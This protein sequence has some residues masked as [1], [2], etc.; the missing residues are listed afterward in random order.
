M[1]SRSASGA[2]ERRAASVPGGWFRGRFRRAI[3]PRP[4]LIIVGYNLL[5]QS[6]HWFNEL[7]SFKS[8][9][10]GLGL[11]VQI[12]VPRATE[13]PLAAALSADPVLESLPPLEVNAENFVT[14][15]VAFG[16]AAEI[17]QLLWA[18]L[19]AENPRQADMIYFPRGHPVL[20]RA[21]GLWLAKQ[22]PARRPNVFFRI[23][24]DEL[25]DLETGRFK[26]RASFYRLACADLRMQPGQER[27]FFLVNSAAKARSVSRVCCRQAF[28]MQHHFGRVADLLAADP[29]KPTIYVHLNVRSGRLA[30]NLGDIIGRVAAIEPSVKFLIRVPVEFS[31]AIAALEPQIASFVA[32]ISPEQN[33]A[34]YFKNLAR[35][36][37]VLLAYEAQ[38]Y[39][40][41]TSGVFTEAASL[42]KPVV[43]P[44]GTW[45]AQKIV[46]G[47]GVGMVFED[48]SAESVAGVL[49]HALQ[50]SDQLGAAAREIAPRLGEETGC[51]RFIEDMLA[52]SRSTPDMEP[53]Y[54]IGDDIDFAD[55]LD[56]RC[57]MRG[58]WGETE[59]W[60][61]WTVGG[62]ADLTLRLE[63]DP[64]G[65]L[66]LNALVTA[67]LQPTQ[68]QVPIRVLLAGRQIAEWVFVGDDPQKDQFRWYSA[69]LPPRAGDPLCR[70]VEISFAV[71]GATSPFA[72]GLSDDRRTLG[73]GLRKLS[74]TVE[75]R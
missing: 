58:G 59:S 3:A 20:I 37:M 66:I 54:R 72:L 46:E 50:T 73:M 16:D 30:A 15:L 69:R 22:P 45:M 71:D 38:P 47:Y 6:S 17:P 14:Q 63:D 34:D 60:G 53:R 42:G 68:R 9:G 39:K 62:H 35:C 25:T 48:P 36:T 61:V 10:L 51:R 70:A 28:M 74:L 1:S 31:E 65:E 26:A 32:I 44:G 75:K 2:K 49:L 11:A 4:K 56:S 24:G 5:D 33:I 57:Y 23:I 21:V 8:E 27:V 67:F 18:R 29:M 12:I 40:A 7:V 55:A 52:L 13:A 19:D 64:G 41:L 43:V